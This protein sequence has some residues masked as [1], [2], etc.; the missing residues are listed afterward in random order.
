ML[1]HMC[2]CIHSTVKKKGA[3]G[4]RRTVLKHVTNVYASFGPVHRL[5]IRLFQLVFLAGTVIFSHNKSVNSVFQPTYQ[6]SR[7][8][9]LSFINSSLL[10]R[11]L[12]LY[13]YNC[14]GSLNPRLT[15]QSWHNP[16]VN[17]NWCIFRWKDYSTWQSKA[18]VLQLATSDLCSPHP[19]V[20][21]RTLRAP[22]T[23][24]IFQKQETTK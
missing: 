24:I 23:I 19:S 3:K 17:C 2:F 11:L 16:L 4:N 21:E 14:C 15:I 5:I 1:E 18:T 22:A 8:G 7:T 13:Q 12:C 6:H 9:P 10:L 20:M